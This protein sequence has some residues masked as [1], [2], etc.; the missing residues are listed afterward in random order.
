MTWRSTPTSKII[1]R[2]LPRPGMRSRDRPRSRYQRGATGGARR[3]EKSLLDITKLSSPPGI[4]VGRRNGREWR[5][6]RRGDRAAIRGK[7]GRQACESTGP[8]KS[9]ENA[10]PSG[11]RP[12]KVLREARRPVCD[13]KSPKS[14]APSTLV[15]GCNLKKSPDPRG[16]TEIARDRGV[17]GGDGGHLP[18]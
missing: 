18:T 16:A 4:S 10:N 11:A 6:A 17:K 13:V 8:P 9:T 7:Y 14:I 15:G 3:R 1:S 12:P 2:N 5:P